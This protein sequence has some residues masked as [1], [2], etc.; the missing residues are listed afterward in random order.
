MQH[1]ANDE[2]R[3]IAKQRGQVVLALSYLP[4]PPGVDAERH[5]DESVAAGKL[6]LGLILVRP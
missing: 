2:W 4:W 6:V 3:Q 5:C 1:P